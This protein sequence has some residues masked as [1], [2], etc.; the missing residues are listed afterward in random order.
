[1]KSVRQLAAS[2][3]GTQLDEERSGTHHYSEHDVCLHK[4]NKMVKEVHLNIFKE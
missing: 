1:M 4:I 3:A 2:S